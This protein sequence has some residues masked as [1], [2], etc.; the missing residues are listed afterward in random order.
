M[1]LCNKYREISVLIKNSIFGNL[2]F[3]IGLL[4]FLMHISQ[5]V[6]SFD[7]LLPDITLKCHPQ[8]AWVAQSFERPTLGFGLG[9]DPTVSWV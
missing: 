7:S 2:G 4:G 9:H 5:S 1:P 6:N 3:R 8:G